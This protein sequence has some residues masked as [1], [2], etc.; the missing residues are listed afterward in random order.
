MIKD[1]QNQPI[2]FYTY[3]E[4]SS[5]CIG[6]HIAAATDAY[7][8]ASL[9]PQALISRVLRAAAATTRVPSRQLRPLTCE[10]DYEL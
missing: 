4:L 8:T 10:N 6:V 9:V 2:V 3:E 1:Q 7:V 5:D